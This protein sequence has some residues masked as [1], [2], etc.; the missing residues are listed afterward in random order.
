[1]K[2]ILLIGLIGLSLSSCTMFPDKY[3]DQEIFYG[4]KLFETRE[5]PKLNRINSSFTYNPEDDYEE[6]EECQENY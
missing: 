5:L 6:C 1:M 4:D 3:S 2:K